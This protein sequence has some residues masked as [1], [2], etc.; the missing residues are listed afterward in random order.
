VWLLG[1]NHC[2][3]F[4]VFLCTLEY[5]KGVL[6]ITTNRAAFIDKAFKSR[7]YLSL[8][9][10]VLN[11]AYQKEIWKSFITRHSPEPAEFSDGDYE[12]FTEHSMKGRKIKNATKLAHLFASRQGRPLAPSHIKAVLEVLNEDLWTENSTTDGRKPW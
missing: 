11:K 5:Y 3:P 4:S 8:N 10:P 2:L 9:Y 1:L 7:I 6:F 12:A